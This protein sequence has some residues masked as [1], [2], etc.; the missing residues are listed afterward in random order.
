MAV[1][2]TVA[3]CWPQKQ[4][5]EKHRRLQLFGIDLLYLLKVRQLSLAHR[6]RVQKVH[7]KNWPQEEQYEYLVNATPSYLGRLK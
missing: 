2:S 3:F 7:C 6:G 1:I 4:A 5:G